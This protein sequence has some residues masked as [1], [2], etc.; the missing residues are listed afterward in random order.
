[1]RIAKRC[2][3]HIKA[4]PASSKEFHRHQ[5][6]H[7]AIIIEARRAPMNGRL[8]GDNVLGQE[9]ATSLLR[10]Q[11]ALRQAG[12][13]A[14]HC[15]VRISD[16]DACS[17]KTGAAAVAVSSTDGRGL[18]PYGGTQLVPSRTTRQLQRCAARTATGQDWRTT[19]GS[20]SCPVDGKTV[21]ARAIGSASLV[22]SPKGPISYGARITCTSVNTSPPPLG[23]GTR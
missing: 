4:T 8:T 15:A 20:T 5:D 6:T 3:C 2:G 21:S 18:C 11:L 7:G 12:L 14:M 23:T 17:A 1:M 22:C 9:G 19:G 10:A 13:A 16:L